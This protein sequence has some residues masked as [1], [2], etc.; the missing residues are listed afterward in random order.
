[1]IENTRPQPLLPVTGTGGVPE[2]DPESAATDEPRDH[3]RPVP[4]GAGFPPRRKRRGRVV[5]FRAVS[6]ARAFG[7]TSHEP[8]VCRGGRAEGSC[9]ARA[10]WGGVST[11]P[12]TTRS[13]RH[14]SRRSTRASFRMRKSRIAS[15]PWRRSRRIM[16]GLILVG[17]GFNPAEN[18]AAASLPLALFHPRDLSVARVTNHASARPRRYI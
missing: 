8:R 10:L 17:R 16:S 9:P 3:V 15:L 11:P 14:L 1:M 5:T 6:P 12:K 4:C 7:C 18:D 2:R 13:C